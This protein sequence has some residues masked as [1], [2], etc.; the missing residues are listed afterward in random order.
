MVAA[1]S[2]FAHPPPSLLPKVEAVLELFV[3][4]ATATAPAQDGSAVAPRPGLHHT[5]TVAAAACAHL[6]AKLAAVLVLVGHGGAVTD[7]ST[8]AAARASAA[9]AGVGAGAGAGAGVGPAPLAVDD[10]EDSKLEGE[11]QDSKE[12]PSSSNQADVA[13]A[14]LTKLV[15]SRLFC[16]GVIDRSTDNAGKLSSWPTFLRELVEGKGAA[17]VLDL[18]LTTHAP[19]S[20]KPKK[21]LIKA[22][23][24][25]A[26]A[27]L[28]HSGLVELAE[29]EAAAAV[30]GD[31]AGQDFSVVPPVYVA[32]ASPAH[33]CFPMSRDSRTPCPPFGVVACCLF[34]VRCA[35]FVC[36]AFA[37]PAGSW[38]TCGRGRMRCV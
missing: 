31:Y 38:T 30:A 6:A 11:V 27:M 1:L 5:F 16:G 21:V 35:L 7:V 12:E 4:C 10:V 34:V 9:G 20:V 22:Q 8:P 32:V 18:W 26:A 14:A 17:H 37:A 15:S 19:V 13:S 33:D 3:R 29:R 2:L 25:V 23:R 24:A 36:C 28:Y